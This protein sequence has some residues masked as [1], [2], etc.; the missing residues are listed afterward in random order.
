MYKFL[1]MDFNKEINKQKLKF[2]SWPKK[3]LEENVHN[4]H[5]VI[6]V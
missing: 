3:C 2:R 6:E 5:K 1:E 4:K